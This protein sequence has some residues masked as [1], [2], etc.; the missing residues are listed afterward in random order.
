MYVVCVY[1]ERGMYKN[2]NYKYHRTLS[3]KIKGLKRTK[4][5]ANV[6]RGSNFFALLV[7]SLAH[8][9]GCIWKLKPLIFTL[10]QDT[11]NVC[12][13]G[14]WNESLAYQALP[15]TPVTFSISELAPSAF[16]ASEHPGLARGGL[17]GCRTHW[18]CR[19]PLYKGQ[20]TR[21]EWRAVWFVCWFFHSACIVLAV[22]PLPITKLISPFNPKDGDGNEQFYYHVI[23]KKLLKVHWVQRAMPKSFK[24]FG[25]KVLGKWIESWMGNL[26]SNEGRREILGTG[27]S[28]GKIRQIYTQHSIINTLRIVGIPEG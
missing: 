12:A 22:Y 18:H 13:M 23:T 24:S 2:M 4:I 19:V 9:Q 25:E 1:R 10:W 21:C 17:A 27:I 16:P 8:A 26:W 5:K 6:I 20:P 7:D 28:P 3:K 14:L 15:L 11:V